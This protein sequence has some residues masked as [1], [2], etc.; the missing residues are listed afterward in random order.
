MK[1]EFNILHISPNF[2]YV[3]GV[4]KYVHIILKGLN[5]FKDKY[6]IK[7]FFI[8]NEG[9][10]LE[11]LSE[12]G[13][14]PHILRFDK[15]IKNIFYIKKN[16]KELEKF[17]ITNK[18]H[19]IHSHHRYPELLSNLLKRKLDIKTITTVHSIIDGFKSLSFKSDKIIA[20]SKSVEEN[21]INK[22]KI[23]PSKIL[24]LYNPIELNNFNNFI[25][26]N[27]RKKLGIPEGAIVFLFVGRWNKIKGTDLMVHVFSNMMKIYKN[28]FLLLITNINN[29]E[30]QKIIKMNKNFIFIKPQENITSFYNLSDA[31]ILPSRVDPF[32]YV[33]LE[34]GLYKKIF[35]GSKVNGIG[36]FIEDEIDVIEHEGALW[37]TCHLHFLI[38]FEVGIDF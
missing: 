24:Q 26:E 31:V 22:Y 7:L 15:G 3:C 10:S 33:M 38:R 25:D 27:D 19:I 12:I 20:V 11:R 16:L 35:I 32:P 8:T 1:N 4:S 14:E 37:M 2:N 36:E 30:K 21:L 29:S 23:D 18:I 34:A 5:S 28:V 13:I 6:N 17:C 9:D